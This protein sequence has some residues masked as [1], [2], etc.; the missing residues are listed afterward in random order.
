MGAVYLQL[1]HLRTI[2]L[3]MSIDQTLVVRAPFVEEPDSILRIKQQNLKTELLRNPAVQKVAC[4]E[5]L[6]GL[7]LH[8]LSTTSNV[9]KVGEEKEAGSYNYYYLSH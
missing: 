2:E 9:T 4:S 8:E 6:P 5:S 1:N 7:E 3:G